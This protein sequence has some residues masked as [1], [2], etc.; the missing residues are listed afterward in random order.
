MFPCNECAKLMIQA[1]GGGGHQRCAGR[2]LEGAASS[3]QQTPAC[4]CASAA[5]RPHG[6]TSLLRATVHAGG[7]TRGRVSRSKG[8]AAAVRQPHQRRLQV[9]QRWWWHKREGGGWGEEA[10]WVGRGR[11]SKAGRGASRQLTF[12]PRCKVT[13]QPRSASLQPRPAVCRVPPPAGAG[14]RAPAAAPL[15]PARAAA[16]DKRCQAARQ[17]ACRLCKQ[18]PDGQRGSRGGGRGGG[19]RAG[20]G[21]RA[22]ARRQ[23]QQR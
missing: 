4:G 8:A 5:A 9:R 19:G 14:R 7:H 12:P 16:P 1:R 17:H 20:G 22:A 2:H 3:T 21:C 23:R 11:A 13:T 6:R 18:Q 10:A 15:Q